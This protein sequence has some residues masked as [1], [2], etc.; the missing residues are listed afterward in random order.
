MNPSERIDALE[1][2]LA[3][4]R[5]KLAAFR[6]ITVDLRIDG[7]VRPVVILAQDDTPAPFTIV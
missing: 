4:L 7:R 1:L 6:P 5:A 3:E 2:Q